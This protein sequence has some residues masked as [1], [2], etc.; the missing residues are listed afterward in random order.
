MN[1]DAG[2][3]ITL[4]RADLTKNARSGNIKE[5]PICRYFKTF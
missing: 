4:L 5:C 1:K 3:V 2:Y